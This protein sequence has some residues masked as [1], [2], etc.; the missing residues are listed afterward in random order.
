MILFR[1]CLEHNIMP[2]IIHNENR[3]EYFAALNAA[4]TAG[5]SKLAAFFEKEQAYYAAQCDFLIYIIGM[6]II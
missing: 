1:E 4:H 5:T 6:K 3:A 2:F